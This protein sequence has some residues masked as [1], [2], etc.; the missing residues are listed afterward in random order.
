MVNIFFDTNYFIYLY[1]KK[2]IVPIPISELEKN[3]LFVS[4]LTYHIFAY[5][6]KLKIP[7]QE[8]T[9]TLKAFNTIE[10]TENILNKA[11][12]GPTGDLEDNIQ[13]HSAAEAECDYFLTLDKKLLSMKFFGKTRIADDLPTSFL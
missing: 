4:V 12:E 13:L 5:T 10:F 1:T 9:S 8:L 6:Q 11:L 7:N 3:D 2:D